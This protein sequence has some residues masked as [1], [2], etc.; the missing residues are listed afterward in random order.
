MLVDVVVQESGNHVVCRCHGVEVTCEVEV[1]LLHREN[2]C[3]STAGCTTL[4]TEAWSE[5][6]LA[7][8]DDRVLSDLVE[9]KRETY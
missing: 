3:I 4:H 9:A 7:E 1:D 2:L 8:S 5:R 6:R